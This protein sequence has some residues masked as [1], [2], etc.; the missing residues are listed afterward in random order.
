MGFLIFEW[1]AAW[2]YYCPLLGS[3]DTRC[4]GRRKTKDKLTETGRFLQPLRIGS[5]EQP[6]IAISIINL[7]ITTNINLIWNYDLSSLYFDLLLNSKIIL[8][9]IALKWKKM[10]VVF[11]ELLSWV[12]CVDELLGGDGDLDSKM[13]VWW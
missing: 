13:L 1:A 2:V 11:R 8:K 7:I 3:F 10:W 9:E 12:G 4:K 5:N 6:I